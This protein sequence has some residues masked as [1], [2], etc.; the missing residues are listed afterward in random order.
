MTR[1]NPD[2][3]YYDASSG[4]AANISQYPGQAGR[5]AAIALKHCFEE[6]NAKLDEHLEKGR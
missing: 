6:L 4:I 1:A 3:F 2:A 5:D